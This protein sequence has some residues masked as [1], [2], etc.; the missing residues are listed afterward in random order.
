MVGSAGNSGFLRWGFSPFSAF[1]FVVNPH[2]RSPHSSGGLPGNAAVVPGVAVVGGTSGRSPAGY[3]DRIR[4][5]TPL[6][7][8]LASALDA[9]AGKLKRIVF[10]STGIPLWTA[11]VS[12]VEPGFVFCF[13]ISGSFLP[14]CLLV[15]GA[16]GNL[17]RQ[18]RLLVLFDLSIFLSLA[19]LEIALFV[20]NC[21]LDV[22]SKFV[23][24]VRLCFPVG[25][26]FGVGACP[27]V[28]VLEFPSSFVSIAF[29]AICQPI[30]GFKTG[31][32]RAM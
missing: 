22:F 7:P 21:F 11:R 31:M 28:P 14:P 6:L 30:Y 2:L 20:W 15:C 10:W 27:L 24:L 9:F 5:E 16:S 26:W 25:P 13:S 12:W 1:I 19:F 3:G 4:S 18:V 32:M 17:W 8:F 23:L 29:S